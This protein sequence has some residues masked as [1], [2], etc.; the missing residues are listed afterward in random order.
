L[1]AVLIGIFTL[2]ALGVIPA[3]AVS[4][5]S[6]PGDVYFGSARCPDGITA[7]PSPD[8]WPFAYPYGTGGGYKTATR[9][10]AGQNSFSPVTAGGSTVTDIVVK[11]ITAKPLTN[12]VVKGGT[13]APTR[14]P[15]KSV[16]K[17]PARPVPSDPTLCK[18]A[19]GKCIPSLP[20]GLDYQAVEILDNAA[21]LPVDCSLSA[22]PGLAADLYDGLACTI[23]TVPA[24]ASV[25]LR[26]VVA[27][28]T[29]GTFQP[30]FSVRFF[31]PY[32]DG[33][34][35]LFMTYGK[36][37]VG[38]PSC[39]GVSSYVPG[40]KALSL[41]NADVSPLC[42][43]AGGGGAATSQSTTI[44]TDG[45]FP[46]GVFASVGNVDSDQCLASVTCFGQLSV[47]HV[48]GGAAI[49]GGLTWT[50]TWAA[51]LLPPDEDGDHDDA[52]PKGVIHFLDGYPA[53]PNAFEQIKFRH[54]TKCGTEIT[55]LC[56]VS[57]TH[58]DAGN[59]TAVLKSPNN[60][61]MKGF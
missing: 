52:R 7:C 61:A 12:L 33:D 14:V 58:D 29:P 16:P 11:N 56:W 49:P 55:G 47:A 20:A 1:A 27:T 21:S 39:S 36:L 38:Q 41:S 59:W 2:S 34:Y 50:I 30:W 28:T 54:S 48:A 17:M 13:T 31:E 45:T 9:T 35:D 40:G 46:K 23:G 44:S 15:R 32:D 19:T 8:G 37:T 57:L 51:D 3:T 25:T 26:I 53:D 42:G 5:A 4:A 18:W 24:G 60:G 6:I 10:I 22:T 43:T